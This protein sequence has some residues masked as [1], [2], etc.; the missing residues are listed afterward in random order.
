MC[1]TLAVVSGV[2]L[3]SVE[4]KACGVIS[5]HSSNLG[6]KVTEKSQ[7]FKGTVPLEPVPLL[8]FVIPDHHV[9]QHGRDA[10]SLGRK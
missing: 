1:K 5:R 8:Y 9:I 2:G 7:I 6:G 3:F 10:N 4:G